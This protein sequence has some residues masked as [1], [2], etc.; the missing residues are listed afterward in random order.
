MRDGRV[1]GPAGGRGLFSPGFFRL[2]S[3]V[4]RASSLGVFSVVSIRK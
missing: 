2:E 3:L 1:I 4:G